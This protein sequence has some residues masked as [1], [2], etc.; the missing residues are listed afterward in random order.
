MFSVGSLLVKCDKYG[1]QYQNKACWSCVCLIVDRTNYTNY[2]FV[3]AIEKVEH[4]FWIT[5][6]KEIHAI[7]KIALN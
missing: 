6:A 4:F 7:K 2:K 3:C 5:D 1:R